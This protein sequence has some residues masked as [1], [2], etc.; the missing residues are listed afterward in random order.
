MRQAFF[1][2][3]EF[4]EKWEKMTLNNA[5]HLQGSSYNIVLFGAGC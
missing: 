2:V 1:E 4:L 3:V 5:K